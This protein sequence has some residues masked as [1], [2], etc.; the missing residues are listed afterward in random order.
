[1]RDQADLHIHSTASDGAMTPTEI[2]QEAARLGLGAISITDHDTLDGLDEALSAAK[3]LG[4]GLVPGVEINCDW[5]DTESHVLG[6]FVDPADP[7][8]QE[9]LVK[10]RAARLERGRAIVSKL[11]ALGVDVTME[12]VLEIAGHGSVGRPHIAQ[13]IC[14]AGATRGIN[15]AFGKFLARGAPAFVPRA[16]MDPEQA[17]AVI[18]GAGGA[19][20]L[21]HPGKIGNDSLIERLVQAGLAALEVYHTDHNRD[22]TRRFRRMAAR[23]G[24]IATGGSDSHGMRGEKPVAIGS[25]TVHV[26][27]VEELRQAARG[28]AHSIPKS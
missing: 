4:V 2:V 10:L 21:G 8:L 23:H 22:A 15:G 27:V 16:K 7:A 5:G 6:Y 3:S 11:Q 12:R 26:N 24:L 19:A 1:M 13:A 17:I 9:S 28:D 14:E 18:I 20:V 25:V